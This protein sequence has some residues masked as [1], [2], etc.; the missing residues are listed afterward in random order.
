[1]FVYMSDDAIIAPRFKKCPQEIP[2]ASMLIGILVGI[3]LLGVLAFIIWKIATYI[4]D[5]REYLKFQ[6]E[7]LNPKWGRSTNPIYNRPVR[8][9]YNPAYGKTE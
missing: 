9:F 3:L 4:Q 7:L 5:K 6:E 2:L 1:M 8:S